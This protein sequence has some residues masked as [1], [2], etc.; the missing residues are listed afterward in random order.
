MILKPNQRSQIMSLPMVLISTISKNGVHNA[1]PWSC[2]AP[3]LRP[4]EY[5]SMLSEPKK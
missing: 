2:V 3:V 4:L 5:V 1:A